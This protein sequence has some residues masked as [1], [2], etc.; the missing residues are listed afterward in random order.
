MEFQKPITQM[1][2]RVG[3]TGGSQTV[4]QGWSIAGPGCPYSSSILYFSGSGYYNLMLSS[5][6]LTFSGS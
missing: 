1:E 5:V 3:L 6:K 4:R 2:M